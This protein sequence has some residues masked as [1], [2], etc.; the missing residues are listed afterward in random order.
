MFVRLEVCLPLS[1]LLFVQ[2]RE[3]A[4]FSSFH[5]CV[6]LIVNY[7]ITL[8]KDLTT[9]ILLFFFFFFSCVIH[10]KTF[11]NRNARLEIISSYLK[12]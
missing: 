8:T 5:G 9:C 4:L 11:C 7:V 10:H 3:V 1:A 2:L 6:L 12:L